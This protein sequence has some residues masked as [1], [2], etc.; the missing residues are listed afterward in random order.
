[1][2]WPAWGEAD[3][4][5][6]PIEEAGIEGFFARSRQL[7]GDGALVGLTDHEFV[8]AMGYVSGFSDGVKDGPDGGDSFLY[9][10]S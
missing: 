6:K 1:M 5:S 7:P 4:A 8:R 3:A 10:S 9:H 2:T